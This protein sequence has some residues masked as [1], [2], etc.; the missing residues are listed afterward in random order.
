MG[1]LVLV[2]AGSLG[3]EVAQWIELSANKPEKIVFLDDFLTAP[4]V[5][6]KIEQAAELVSTEQDGVLL[7]IYDPAAREKVADRVNLQG[8]KFST[9]AHGFS[10]PGFCDLGEG[11]LLLPYALVSCRAK[12]GRSVILNTHASVGHDSEIGDFVTLSSHAAIAGR[13]IVGARTFIGTGAVVI[14]DVKIGS[15]CHIG[16]GAVVVSDLPNGSKVFGNPA[17]RI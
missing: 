5:I 3:H 16:A 1:R 2:G 6:G 8:G 14:P 13:V 15:D 11:C 7:T 9:W 12:L 17:R 4:Y 10:C